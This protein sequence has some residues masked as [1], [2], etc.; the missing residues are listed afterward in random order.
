MS[1]QDD[2]IGLNVLD[3]IDTDVAAQERP[4]SGDRGAPQ[5]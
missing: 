5:A 4:D 1:G 2:R 3:R